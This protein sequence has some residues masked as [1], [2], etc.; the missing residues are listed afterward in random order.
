MYFIVYLFIK[1]VLKKPSAQAIFVI[2]QRGIQPTNIA[3]AVVLNK[4]IEISVRPF[5]LGNEVCVLNEYFFAD[6]YF[7]PVLYV[8]AMLSN[9]QDPQDPSRI[10]IDARFQAS[11]KIFP[12]IL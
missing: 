7:C 5:Q 3:S 9:D 2:N 8:I 6:I 10:K 1:Y 11:I 12:R 4:L